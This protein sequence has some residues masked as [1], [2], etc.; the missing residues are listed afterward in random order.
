MTIA[1]QPYPTVRNFHSKAAHTIS[2]LR[3]NLGEC[4]HQNASLRVEN[5]S[6]RADLQN[7]L[8]TVQSVVRALDACG[9]EQ[10]EFHIKRL[11]KLVG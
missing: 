6:L 5:D 10:Y 11:K 8:G 1:S 4:R 7:T 9:P 3:Q 2:T